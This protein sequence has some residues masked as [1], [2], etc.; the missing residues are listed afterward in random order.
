MQL[1]LACQLLAPLNI[2][3]CSFTQ[4][5]WH[6]TG[7]ENGMVHCESYTLPVLT[8]GDHGPS[9][10]A[11][12]LDCTFKPLTLSR[13]LNQLY[14][15]PAHF[16]EASTGDEDNGPKCSDNS[17]TSTVSHRAVGAAGQR[18]CWADWRSLGPPVIPPA[19][20]CTSSG[21]ECRCSFGYSVVHHTSSSRSLLSSDDCKSTKYNNMK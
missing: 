1:F 4:P 2:H 7:T 9:T 6:P 12:I 19:A 18:N 10:Q 14:I 17:V 15:W 16:S 8:G 5:Y 13:V 11:Y 3:Y 20:S 21:L